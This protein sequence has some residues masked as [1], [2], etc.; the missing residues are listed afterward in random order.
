M[1]RDA[2]NAKRLKR[3]WYLR[4]R[5]LTLARSKQWAEANPDKRQEFRAKY[6]DENRD[7]HN[8][9]NRAWFAEN[10]DKRAAYEGKRRAS[11]LQRTP[12]WLT[13]ED[14]W[15]IEQAYEL[16]KIRTS[17]FG[18]E[19]HVDHVIPLQ[20]KKV[21]GLH[22]PANLQVIPGSENCRK[23]AKFLT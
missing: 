1:A 23:N 8:S 13:D 12:Q 18:F 2:E 5:E 15:I 14:Q 9:Y 21:S 3:E 16:A 17:C 19:W 4:H 22:V 20:G 7:K 11:M 10:P 6:R